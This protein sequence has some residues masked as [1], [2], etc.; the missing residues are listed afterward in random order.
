VNRVL[1]DPF[2][3]AEAEGKEGTDLVARVA[4]ACAVL[5][6]RPLTVDLV[7][8][9]DVLALPEVGTLAARPG[10]CRV[11]VDGHGRVAVD[12]IVTEPVRHEARLGSLSL[13][14]EDRDPARD[15]FGHPVAGPLTRDE[16]AEWQL[17]LDAAAEV[18]AARH[19]EALTE[20]A[21]ALTTLVPLVPRADGHSSATARNAFGAL[22]IALP[23]P[24]GH[25]DT[26]EALASLLLHE[27][28]H[29]KLGAVLDMF[30]L[31]DGSDGDGYSVGWRIDRRSLEAV[32]QGVYAHLAVADY[33]YRRAD[34]AVLQ[35]KEG[36]AL[37]GAK[38]MSQVTE[39]LEVIESSRALTPLGERWVRG[40]VAA[41][42][43][44]R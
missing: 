1:A 21:E 15:R 23:G 41:A 16:L 14:I 44:W 27:F 8:T 6:R 26:G 35:P 28:Q 19:P 38:I 9:D 33:W 39:A 18:L 40:M 5:G 12:G 30:A 7:A 24:C 2:L 36:Y 37:Q 31:H 43:Q 11:A 42:G 34:A 13:R 29:L 4:L 32:I 3:A 10:P 25:P 22:A 20:M 17:A